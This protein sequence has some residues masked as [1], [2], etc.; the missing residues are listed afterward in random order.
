LKNVQAVYDNFE[1]CAEARV[2]ILAK[3]AEKMQQNCKIVRIRKLFSVIPFY[4]MAK[5]KCSLT[6]RHIYKLKI[7]TK[8]NI[9]AL[10]VHYK[11]V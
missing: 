3:S 1:S 2:L 6:R 8:S 7:K 11:I 4:V 5:L 10:S 9:L